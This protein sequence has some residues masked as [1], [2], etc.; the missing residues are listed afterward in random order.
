MKKR[1][2][3]L[4]RLGVVGFM[5]VVLLTGF[6]FFAS[7]PLPFPWVQNI[8]FGKGA[9]LCPLYHGLRVGVGRRRC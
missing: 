7:S 6:H 4:E 1:G 5:N 3:V 2:E 8:F 9:V